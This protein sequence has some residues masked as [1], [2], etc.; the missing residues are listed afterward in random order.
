MAED[1]EN[2]E[3]TKRSLNAL[4]AL[5]QRISSKPPQ[6][7][8]VDIEEDNTKKLT[9]AMQTLGGYEVLV[10]IPEA[11]GPPTPGSTIT[12]A[13]L[14]YIHETGSPIN[15]IP[16]RPFLRPG[17]KNSASKWQPKLAD[18]AQAA[19]QG[20]QGAML[21]KLADA[22]IIASNAVKRTIQAGIPPPLK[23]DT[24]RRRRKRS[25]GSKYR[26]KATTPADVTPLID[27]GALLRSITYVV[28]KV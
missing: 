12:N 13:A 10:G 23:P 4:D 25:P 5:R 3:N 1:D 7:R 19:L 15:N 20:D 6:D 9:S 11:Y 26:R 28:V 16:A 27:T 21:A 22:G 2:T 17:V 8:P 14:G 18:A 24:V